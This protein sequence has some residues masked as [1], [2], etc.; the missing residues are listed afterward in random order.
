M[1]QKEWTGSA[2]TNTNTDFSGLTTGK[3]Y[4][5]YITH[6]SGVTSTVTALQLGADDT[7]YIAID[8]DGTAISIDGSGRTGFRLNARSE[9]LRLTTAST[10][11]GSV[12]FK[13]YEIPHGH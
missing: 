12:Y 5:V 10:S 13:V 8:I 4:G 11:G 7:T 2:S 3:N 6:P 1:A 9:T